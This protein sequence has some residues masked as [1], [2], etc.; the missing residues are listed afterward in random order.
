MLATQTQW[1]PPVAHGAALSVTAYFLEFSES[2]LPSAFQVLDSSQV[3]FTFLI[4]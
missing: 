1:S 4:I 3:R 2:G